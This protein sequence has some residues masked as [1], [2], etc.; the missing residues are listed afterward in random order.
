MRQAGVPNKNIF[1]GVEVHQ[2]RP[3]FAWTEP[4]WCEVVMPQ[5]HHTNLKLP[6]SDAKPQVIHIDTLSLIRH[7]FGFSYRAGKME[8]ILSGYLPEKV[9]ARA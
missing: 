4:V 5:P 2:S 3:S 7:P 1:V 6:I 9:S 8:Y